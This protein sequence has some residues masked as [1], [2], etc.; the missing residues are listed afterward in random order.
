[1]GD[2]LY[3]A[4][5]DMALKAHSRL[6]LQSYL[7]VFSYQGPKSFGPLQAEAPREI[8]RDSYGIA[9]FDDTFYIL[10]N[11]YNNQ[12]LDLSGKQVSATITRCLINFMGFVPNAMPGCVFRPYTETEANYLNFG[13]WSQPQ[14]L[15]DFRSQDDIRFWN[16]LIQDMIE[17]TATPLPYFPYTEYDS[18]RAATWSLLGFLLLMIIIVIVLVLMICIKRNEENRSLKLLRARDRE[19]EERYNEQP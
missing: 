2:F 4:P 19:F 15:R 16:D 17:Y 18:F 5:A 1:M 9:H 11:E 7:Y 6:G 13:P 12:D 10:P 14:A 8:T 3:N